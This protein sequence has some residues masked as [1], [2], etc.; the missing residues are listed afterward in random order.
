MKPD[1]MTTRERFRAVMNFQPFDRLPLW[2]LA[3]WWN[4]T[5]DRWEKEGL[6]AIIGRNH[7]GNRDFSWAEQISAHFGQDIYLEDWIDPFLPSLGDQRPAHGAPIV[8]SMDDYE[9]ILPHLYPDPAKH[10]DLD[11][12]RVRAARQARGEIVLWISLNGAFW[13]PRVLLGI[14]GH[15]YAHYDQPELIHRINS[16][17]ADWNIR[18]IETICAIATPDFMASHE[19]MSY[20]HGSM[21][22]EKQFDEFLLP[23]YRHLI[24][25]LHDRGILA[26][27]DSDGDITT[28][29]PWFERA[30]LDGIFPL[31][32]Q[33]HVDID[34][35]RR[36]HPRMRFMGHF[37]KLVMDKGEAAMRAEFERLL[38]AAS[39]GGFLISVDHQTPPNVSY[40]DYQL[41]MRLFREYAEAAGAGK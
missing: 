28:A 10:V 31:E 21:L 22:S 38:P 7:Q 33:S 32:R 29:A 27:A 2:E 14:E 41:Y 8:E 17:L 40:Q 13:F 6:P 23:Y 12:W 16:D 37:D 9:R 3:I 36:N 18:C 11:L 35:L 24:P 25:Y 39:K 30:G 4:L 1:K 20:N 19:D 5:I 15:L 34:V 26:I